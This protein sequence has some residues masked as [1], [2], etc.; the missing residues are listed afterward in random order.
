MSKMVQ[1][2]QK[3]NGGK[4]QIKMYKLGGKWYEFKI[5]P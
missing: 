1:N 2:R 4:I 5:L 3:V